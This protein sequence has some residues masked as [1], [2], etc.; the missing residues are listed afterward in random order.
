M[1]NYSLERYDIFIAYSL[2]EYSN[3]KEARL[4]GN[5]INAKGIY[6]YLTDL[7]YDCFLQ[8]PDEP[9]RRYDETPSMA[10]KCKLFLL[11][12]DLTIIDKQKKADSPKQSWWYNELNGFISQPMIDG[13][14]EIAKEYIQVY[15]TDEELSDLAINN[16]H[17]TFRHMNPIRTLDNLKKW[18]ESR[19]GIS[20]K[21]KIKTK[22]SEASNGEGWDQ[23]VADFWQSVFPPAC[24]SKSEL[25]FYEKYFDEVK[26]H[27]YVQAE[28]LILGSTKKFIE[29]A[30][31]K[32]YIITVVD[33]SEEYY[34]R[35]IESISS[36]KALKN[37]RVV[38]SDWANM[39]CHESLK[40]KKFDII[41]GDMAIGNIKPSDLKKTIQ[42]ICNLLKDEGY[43]LGKNLFRFS[44]ERSYNSVVK[45]V[46]KLLLTD[47]GL[48]EE[49][50]FSST[51]YD[52]VMFSF[53]T[54][55]RNRNMIT[56]HKMDFRRLSEVAN[57]ISDNLI[58]NS[59]IDPKLFKVTYGKYKK[60][61]RK[62][63]AFYIYHLKDFISLVKNY[64]IQL[65]DVGYGNDLYSENFPLL[66]FK[67]N[68]KDTI[69]RSRIEKAVSAI[70]T[71]LPRYQS[72]EYVRQWVNY[73]P[74]QY[75]LIRLSELA[76]MAKDTVWKETCN[77]IKKD[78]IKSVKVQV[79]NNLRC[80]VDSL[81]DKKIDEEVFLI[82]NINTLNPIEQKQIKETYKLAVLLYLSSI[83]VDDQK[84][85]SALCHLVVNKLVEAPQYN[86][87]IKCWGPIG[88]PWIT[89]KVCMSAY[90]LDI[91][92][93]EN[94]KFLLAIQELIKSYDEEHEHNWKCTVGSHM[95]TCALCVEAILSYYDRLSEDFKDKAKAVF[96]DIL[97]AYVLNDNVYETIAFHPLGGY[98][99]EQLQTNQSKL[100]EPYQKKVLGSVAFFSSLL[101]II[102]FLKKENEKVMN[103]KEYEEVILQHLLDFWELFKS[104]NENVYLSINSKDICTIPQILYSLSEAFSSEKD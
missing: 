3:S 63:I 40:D 5:Y 30:S 68:Y 12:T 42:S 34:K 20:P 76:D 103:N 69:D 88:A 89:A 9:A 51:V 104:L 15:T 14:H 37:C 48:T 90:D 19:P 93:K 33:S 91:P 11:V 55:N 60:L 87:A 74:S 96:Y 71:F 73:Y 58:K 102:T 26:Q 45:S 92:K 64:G 1:D 94:E 7:G 59:K 81:E 72:K 98:A 85:K 49:E 97:D 53:T 43:W 8:D 70:N 47:T 17:E 65:Y 99:I 18:I 6:N 4:Q 78:I 10:A 95:D 83:L 38:I 24:P 77:E 23:E 61:K 62:N 84:E 80:F 75:Y 82:K 79:N 56:Y 66:V 46:N 31:K 54:E 57:E 44:H 28:V 27:S 101:R 100:N 35:V 32:H 67:K 21:K 86:S 22:N 16:L 13:K 52:I 29:L 25:D 36:E 50:V 2:V 39:D 41:I